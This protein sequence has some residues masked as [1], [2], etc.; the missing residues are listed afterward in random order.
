MWAK[1]NQQKGFTIVEL[2][3]VIVVIGI[4]AAITIVAYNGVQSRANDVAVQADLRNFHNI[5]AQ[6]KA[7]NGTY[8]TILTTSM[9][10]KFS[11]GAYGLDYQNLN[12]RYCYNSATDNYIIYGLSRSGN[13]FRYVGDSG[14][15]SASNTYGWGIC[16]QIGLTNTNPS[17]NGLSGTTWDSSWVN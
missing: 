2:L 7:I 10:I 4:L 13:Y 8:P 5:I 9:G 15:S 12:V 14:L 1:H 11:R 17:Q 6:Q 16:S 3:I